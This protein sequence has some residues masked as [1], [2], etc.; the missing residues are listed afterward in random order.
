[1]Q[2][3]R[4][5]VLRMAARHWFMEALAEYAA[6]YQVYPED[7]A[8]IDTQMTASWFF[9]TLLRADDSANYQSSHFIH[10]MLTRTNASLRTLF[11]AV[12]A[13]AAKLLIETLEYPSI[14]L[15]G[16]NARATLSR[17]LT[18]QPLEQFVRQRIDGTDLT[19]LMREFVAHAVRIS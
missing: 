9:E 8:G 17:A 14:S 13:D 1:M 15:M 10:D 19:T 6:F 16:K 4:A 5:N 12:V 2:N 18:S 11:T 7:L 3:A